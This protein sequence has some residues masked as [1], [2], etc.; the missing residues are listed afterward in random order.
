[1]RTTERYT[2]AAVIL[3]MLGVDTIFRYP[4]GAIMPIYEELFRQS[5]I[6]R[7]LVRHEAGAAHAAQGYERDLKDQSGPR[8]SGLLLLLATVAGVVD[9]A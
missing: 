7:V 2:G 3:K 8:G 1:M 5:R 4:S 9:D 6:R